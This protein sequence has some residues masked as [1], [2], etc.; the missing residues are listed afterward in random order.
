[1][2]CPKAR[3]CHTGSIAIAAPATSTTSQPGADR[4]SAWRTTT[5]AAA[6]QPA[7]APVHSAA[8]SHPGTIAS[9]TSTI[10]ANGG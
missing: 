5:T 10:A 2:T 8:A 6:M 1:M 4:P 9:G 7:L 3:F